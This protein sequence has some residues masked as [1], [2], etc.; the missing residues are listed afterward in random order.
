MV[1]ANRNH[2][3]HPGR[4]P[5][6][7]ATTAGP[8]NRPP[9][10]VLAVVTPGGDVHQVSGRDTTDP[11]AMQASARE[12][13]A[14]LRQATWLGAR[15]RCPGWAVEARQDLLAAVAPGDLA[16]CRVEVQTPGAGANGYRAVA[17]PLVR[18]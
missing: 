6:P 5:D 8:H 4:R 16:R 10:L 9:V 2:A 1:S 15:F 7:A 11:A 17:L 18:A 14:A 13:R 3:Q 12:L